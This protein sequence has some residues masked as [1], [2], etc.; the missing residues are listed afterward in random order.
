MRAATSPARDQVPP[1]ARAAEETTLVLLPGLD[2]TGLVFEP[3]LE[4]LSG[5]IAA[6]VVRYPDERPMSFQEHIDYVRGQLPAEGPFVLLAE[7]FSGPVGLQLLAEPPRNL[8]GVILVATFARYPSPF[9]LD[10]ARWLPQ[11]PLLKLFA[12]TLC[13]R[14]LCLG[15]APS[16]AVQLFRR[17]LL[18]VRLSV[19]SRRLQILAELPPPPD[20]RFAGPCLYLQPRHD[21]LV[22]PRAAAELQRYLPQLRVEQ[23]GG[24]HII[25]LARPAAGAALIGD[26]IT[27]LANQKPQASSPSSSHR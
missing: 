15:G 12:S 23:L 10:L 1:A 25:L 26:F 27:S 9:V 6:R 13:S 11:R 22:P 16:E 2:G 24:P 17:A 7:S 21:R 20:T 8:R 14:L 4:H 18:S 5:E 3:L 19:L